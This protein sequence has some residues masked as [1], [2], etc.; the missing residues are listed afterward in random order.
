[1]PG[2]ID[3]TNYEVYQEG[4]RIT[5]TFLYRR[6]VRNEQLWQIFKDNT[7]IP[8]LIWGDMQAMMAGMKLLDVRI[9]EICDRYGV[10]SL[11]ESIDDVLELSAQK[12]RDAL[13]KLRD[14]T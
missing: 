4:L 2:S 13:R 14:G 7:R 9:R 10:D 5:P 3:P 8:D 1:M 6:G 12:G 11:L